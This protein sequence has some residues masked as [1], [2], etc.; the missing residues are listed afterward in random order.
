[1]IKRLYARIRHIE[2]IVSEK[3]D[4]EFNLRMK[5][6]E[7]MQAFENASADLLSSKIEAKT[8]LPDMIERFKKLKIPV[9]HIDVDVQ[10][11]KSWMS[12]FSDICLFYDC[13]GDVRW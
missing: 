5:I 1:M 12:R 8:P 7:Q 9:H 13:M 2:Q 3:L 11:F 4:N 10:D 6:Y